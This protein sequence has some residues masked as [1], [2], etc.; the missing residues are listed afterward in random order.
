MPH[1]TAAGSFDVSLTPLTLDQPGDDSARGRMLL[2]KRFHGGLDA[3]GVGEMLTGMGAVA[4]SAA[5]VAIERISGTLAGRSGSFLVV[6]RG[7]M[8]RGTQDLR[9][10]IVPDS[11]TGELTGIAGD[12]TLIVG[13]G[14]HDYRIDATVPDAA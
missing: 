8:T 13:A 7:V 14:R 10:S 5:Y 3:T 12:M 4:G 11:G 1:L 2:S 9:V 6:H